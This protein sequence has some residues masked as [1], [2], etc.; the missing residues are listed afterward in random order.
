MPLSSSTGI[1]TML[2]TG[3]ITSSDLVAMPR[4]LEAAAHAPPI[5]RVMRT[6]RTMPPAEPRMPISR[7]R[8]TRISGLHE[9]L[10]HVAHQPP[11]QQRSRGSPG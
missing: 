3:A 5:T 4:A 7:P 8:P 11:D 6:P 10:Q 9:Q 2:M 1:I